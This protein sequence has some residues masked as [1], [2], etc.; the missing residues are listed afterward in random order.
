[1]ECICID[2]FCHGRL[3]EM[4]YHIIHITAFL[5]SLTVTSNA[6]TWHN[7]SQAVERGAL[8]NDFSPAGYFIQNNH[9]IMSLNSSTIRQPLSGKWVIFLEGGGG[10]TSPR[11]CNERFIEQSIRKKHTQTINDSTY[12][13]VIK[14]W[15]KYRDNPLA[16]TSRLMTTLWRFSEKYRANNSNVWTIQGRDLLS[17]DAHENPDFHNYN[18]VLIPYC[19]SDLWLKNTSNHIKAQDRNF[20]FHFDPDLTTEHQFTFRGATIFRSVIKDLFTYHGLSNATH[21]LLAGSSAGGIGAM[22]HAAWLEEKLRELTSSQSQLH[23]MLDSAWFIDFHGSIGNEFTP[24]EILKLVQNGEVVRTCDANN[25]L[26]CILAQTLLSNPRYYPTD[27]PTLVIFS[28]YDLYLLAAVLNQLS[29][30][31]IIG[32]MRTVAEYAGS[33]NA[34][35]QNVASLNQIATN[36]SYYI[37]SCFQHVHFATSTLWGDS[38]LLGNEDIGVSF[39]SSRFRYAIVASQNNTQNSTIMP[40]SNS[41]NITISYINLLCTYL[42]ISVV[43]NK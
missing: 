11:S 17:T 38:D 43:I 14:A 34:T 15:N 36:L 16:V 6:L 41:H 28:R 3:A 5:L 4:A 30:T 22:N 8:C 29:S 31:N 20:Q 12:I 33:M 21:I 13:D 24:E 35:L 2:T 42:I 1:M 39:E 23:V 32:V 9:N 40:A 37:S 7:I 19:S 25:P 18:H 26:S 10:C 27:I